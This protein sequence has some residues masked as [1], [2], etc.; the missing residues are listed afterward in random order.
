V[1]QVLAA[2]ECRVFLVIGIWSAIKKPRNAK[3]DVFLG[4]WRQDASGK[5]VLV[6]E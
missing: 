6:S 1:I 2:A 4:R 3:V 5:D